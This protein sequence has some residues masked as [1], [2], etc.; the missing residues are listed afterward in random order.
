MLVETDGV[1]RVLERLG[2]QTRLPTTKPGR[3]R[4]EPARELLDPPGNI[5]AGRAAATPSEA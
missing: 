5:H 4:R 1:F 3:D 2:L